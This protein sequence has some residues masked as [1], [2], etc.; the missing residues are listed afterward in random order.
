LDQR[1]GDYG[2]PQG[3]ASW[4]LLLA[5][6]L[7]SAFGFYVW[8]QQNKVTHSVPRQIEVAEADSSGPLPGPDTAGPVALPGRGPF[9]NPPS[10]DTGPFIAPS[11]MFERSSSV[12]VA[13]LLDY[14]RRMRFDPAR[15]TEFAL[16]VDEYGRERMVRIEPLA[17]L[18]RLDST[19]ISE[20]RIIARIRSDAALPTLS[21][22]NGES[23][24]WLQGTLGAPLQAEV[25]STSVVVPPKVLRLTF[26][27]RAPVNAPEGRDAFWVGGDLNNRVLWIACG[28]G[29]CHS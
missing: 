16:P 3:T 10:P 29:W 25:W 17:N 24:V 18:R 1:N 5:L 6:V 28:R 15:G 8:Y 13:N 19:A 7:V 12:P 11:P 23:F 22:H 26:T 9:T 27:T 14:A 4:W 20:G 2:T 21:L